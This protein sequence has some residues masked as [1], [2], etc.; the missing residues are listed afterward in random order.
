MAENYLQKQLSSVYDR[1]AGTVASDLESY[2]QELIASDVKETEP[3]KSAAEETIEVANSEMGEAMSLVDQIA[4]DNAKAKFSSGAAIARAIGRNINKK[5]K[6][7]SQINR[8][9]DIQHNDVFEGTYYNPLTGEKESV[10]HEFSIDESDYETDVLDQF[11]EQL[12]SNGEGFRKLVSDSESFGANGAERNARV[13][14]D[15]ETFFGEQ[16]IRLT[17]G[18]KDLLQS[19]V[20]ARRNAAKTFMTEYN[21]QQVASIQKAR[22]AAQSK[23][24]DA[25]ADLRQ[26]ITQDQQDLAR[27]G[28]KRRKSRKVRMT[29]TVDA[30]R[31]T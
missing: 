4:A 6:A 11:S 8:A 17:E 22:D 29:N 12:F 19:E 3:T 13:Q 18:R 21:E 14:K 1:I 7:I 5:N 30:K 15:M 28:A 31:P 27:L 24:A 10:L 25:S 26:S 23:A 16:Q 20:D 9:A 2:N